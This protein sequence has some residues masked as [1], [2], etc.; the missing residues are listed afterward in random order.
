MNPL[1]IIPLKLRQ[2]RPRLRE[3][4]NNIPKSTRGKDIKPPQ[5]PTPRINNS[6]LRITGDKHCTAR[7]HFTSDSIN[8]DFPLSLK[9]MVYFSLA[10][11]VGAEVSRARRTDCN[12]GGEV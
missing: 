10:V 3:S 1:A 4:I 11:S 9:D 7:I 6:M 5:I 8:R 12:A 2:R